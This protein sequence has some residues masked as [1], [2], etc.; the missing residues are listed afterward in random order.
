[1]AGEQFSPARCEIVVQPGSDPPLTSFCDFECRRVVSSERELS[2]GVPRERPLRS[3]PMLALNP[4]MP[5]T[6]GFQ[7]LM[8]RAVIVC[9]TRC[10]LICDFARDTPRSQP[11][12]RKRSLWSSPRWATYTSGTSTRAGVN[13]CRRRGARQD[14]A[15]LGVGGYFASN[16]GTATAAPARGFRLL[17]D[18]SRR[19]CRSGRA[20]TRTRPSGFRSVCRGRIARPRRCARTRPS[21]RR[22][23]E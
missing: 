10:G 17:S 13:T 15:Q 2:V 16:A 23:V 5:T 12:I 18:W 8:Q 3:A 6:G 9:R 4:E 22:R 14:T 7:G 19:S 20:P 1:V 21:M 11:F